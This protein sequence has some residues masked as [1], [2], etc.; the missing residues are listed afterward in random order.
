[1]VQI[2]ATRIK[3]FEKPHLQTSPLPHNSQPGLPKTGFLIKFYSVNN[4]FQ[5][6]TL[7]QKITFGIT[8]AFSLS[9][10]SCD[11]EAQITPD[12]PSGSA[13]VGA[14]NDIILPSTGM[15]KNYQLNRL[16]KFY[17]TY[18]A[19]GRLK[20]VTEGRSKIGP[21][22]TNYYEDYTYNPGPNNTST[23]H[24]VSSKING[25]GVE[26]TFWINDLGRCNKSEEIVTESNGKVTKTEKIFLYNAKGQLTNCMF[27]GNGHVHYDYNA[28]GDVTLATEYS[29]SFKALKRTEFYYTE[30]IA[31]HDPLQK[32]FYPINSL[33]PTM[34][35]LYL[36]IFGKLSTHLVRTKIEKGP[37][38]AW[39]ELDSYEYK[40]NADGYVTERK[41]YQFG[42]IKETQPYIYTVT[43]KGINP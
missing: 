23:I 14:A 11:K 28:D 27:D 26:K 37:D 30:G 18:Y 35:D 8:L 25:A 24:V 4:T 2:K 9:L 15:P 40:T 31:G 6:N 43:E 12:R 32:D 13:R 42:C 22:N 41:Y 5:M 19:D 38:N 3:I 29:S 34:G 7:L 33:W 21:G 1:M 16:G 17:L 20:R 39:D 10:A 36:P